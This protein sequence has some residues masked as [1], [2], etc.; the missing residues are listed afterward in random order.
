MTSDKMIRFLKSIKIDN[1]DDFDLDFEMIGRNRFNKEQFD[2]IILKKTPWKFYLLQ[3]FMDCLNNIQ[4]KYTIQFSYIECPKSED[5]NELFKDWYKSIYRSDSP[6]DI[7]IDESK[8]TFNIATNESDISIYKPVVDDFNC[9]LNFIGYEYVALLNRVDPLPNADMSKK[10]IKEITKTAAT[11]AKEEIKEEIQNPVN[12]KSYEDKNEEN[13]EVNSNIQQE[14]EDF[15][16]QL[17]K[18]MKN[19]YDEMLKQRERARLNKRGNYNPIDNI[20]EIDSNSG[21]ID[22]NGKIFSSE[23]NDKGRV[24]KI[25]IGI[26]DEYGGAIY[27]SMYENKQVNSEFMA[28]LIRGVNIRVRGVSYIDDFTKSLMVK[29]HFL[30][31]LPPDEIKHENSP[32]PRV[33]LHLHSQMSVQDGVGAMKDYMSYAKALGHKAMAITD[34]G[35]VQ[36]FPDAFKSGKDNGIK[37][38]YGCELYMVDDQLDYV[39]NPCD[40]ELNKATYV[41]LDLETTGLSCRYNRMMEFG[42][43]KVEKGVVT[44]RLDLLINPGVKISE[45]ISN[46]TNITNEMVKDKPLAKE[47]LKEICEFVKD[48]IIVTHNASFD[49]NFLNEELKRNGMD[50]LKNPVIDTLSLSRYLFPENRRHNLGSLCRNMDVTYDEESAHRADYDAE[51]LNEVWQPMLVSLTK[52]NP[53]LKHSDLAKLKTPIEL[54][55]HIMP[56]HV[57]VLAKNKE[58]LKNLYQLVS[59]GHI[60]YLAGLPKVPRF[61]IEKHRHDLLVGSACFNGEVFRS[62]RYDNEEDIKKKIKFYDYIELQPLENYSYLVNMGEMSEEEVELCVKD[63]IRL[64]KSENKLVVATGDVH[65]VKKEDKVFRDVYINSQ[66][67]GGVNHPLNPYARSKVEKFEN[68]NQHYRS[69][70]EMLSCFS[71]LPSD[72]AYEIVVKNTNEIADQIEEIEPIPSDKLYTPKIENCEEMLSS[73]CYEN[74]HKLYGEELPEYIEKRLKTELNGIISNGFSVI[75]WIAHCLV[76]KANDDGY[77]VGS[78]G[79][80]G[81]SFVATMS[82][83]TEVNPLPPHYRCPKCKHLEWTSETYPNIKSGYD[84]PKKKCPICGEEMVCDGQNIPF[85]TFLGF[86]A[87]KVPDIDLNFP[88]DYQAKAHEYT[89]VLLGADNVYRAGT[90]ETVAEKTAFGFARGYL[91][92]MGYDLTKTP[93]AKIAYLASGCVDVKR[94]TGQHPGGIVVIPRDH[95]VYD[96]TAIQ[97]PA[98]EKDATWKTTHFDFHSLHDTILKLD[99]LGHVDPLALKMMCTLTGIN[100]KDIPLND[101]DVLKLFSSPDS[102]HLSHNYLAQKTGALAIPEFGT[103]FVRG[104]LESTKPTT[105]NE[106]IIISGLSHGT[107][108][109]NGNAEKLIKDGTATLQEVIGCRDDIMTFLISKGLPSSVSFKIMEDV[110]KGRGLKPEYEEAMKANNV[111][112]YYIES[113]KQIKYLFPKGH[114]TAYVMM[115][116]RVGYF[117]IHYPLEFYATFFSVRSKQYDIV[118]M[119]KGEAA[120]IE[121]FEYLKLKDRSKAE[122]LSP[123]EEEQLKTLQICIEM[124]QRGFKF[125]NIDLYKSAATSFVVDHENNALYPPFITLDGLGESAATSVIEARNNGEFLSK[126]DLLR[127]TKLSSTN[128]KDLENLGVLKGMPDNDQLSLFDF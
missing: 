89:K 83:I 5:L 48:S 35:V 103:E 17:L 27:V 14:L 74:A 111:P 18:E 78:R 21:N 127:R 99:L 24:K 109:W 87:E 92:R 47:A 123:K 2:M 106:L 91:E 93:K 26:A 50:E 105:I 70:D 56:E 7:K 8:I 66:Q 28:K 65:Y 6:F 42:A 94:T 19:N 59:I 63:I 15:Q 113:C 100:I 1:I 34:H 22:F 30:D 23:I 96:F 44:Q 85:E 121:R 115:A 118:P 64:A 114:A 84:L 51:V 62:A 29:G 122:K 102:L 110:R 77:L 97:Y 82:D 9:F 67:V 55:K 38:L 71:F 125:H 52:D 13:K 20:D 53:H 112:N 79:S 119:V 72:L 128:V 43:V 98:D 116:L 41:V 73:L 86:K 124:V 11:I 54:L 61:E 25:T 107:N 117:K 40:I 95:S 12:E 58:G 16:T 31:L 108:V 36:G 75:Y 101:P 10:Q 90:I 81:S 126:E 46:I 57:V 76:K 69:T 32:V 45:K 104:I 80:V 33:E 88:G 120:L 68:P 39:F 60:E 49:Y 37:V 4:Y 3:Q